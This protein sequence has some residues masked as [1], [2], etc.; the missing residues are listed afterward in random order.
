MTFRLADHGNTFSTRPYGAELRDEVLAATAG[1]ERIVIDLCGVL[2]MSASFADEFAGELVCPVDA[3]AA[4]ADVDFAGASAEVKHVLDRAL[5]RRS[6]RR[7]E[8][9]R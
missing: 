3:R 6:A 5:A 2:S 9:A 1:Q 8:L 4:T 7:L